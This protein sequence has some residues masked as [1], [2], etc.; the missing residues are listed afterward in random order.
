VEVAGLYLE[1]TALQPGRQQPSSSTHQQQHP[2]HSHH[3]RLCCPFS[4]SRR[5]CCRRLHVDAR[6]APRSS[7]LPPVIAALSPA[8]AAV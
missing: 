8:A 2:Q 5:S 1:M 3:R 4:L 7:S 6:P